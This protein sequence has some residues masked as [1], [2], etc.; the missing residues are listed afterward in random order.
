MKKGNL[1]FRH[2]HT[3]KTNFQFQPFPFNFFFKESTFLERAPG[4]SH[5]SGGP[6]LAGRASFLR[7]KEICELL[8]A[9]ATTRA[10]EGPGAPRDSGRRLRQTRDREK[11]PYSSTTCGTACLRIL[12]RGGSK[13]E[14]ELGLSLRDIVGPGAS[15]S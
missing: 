6:Q 11:I 2:L 7:K 14:P 3:I 8:Y 4:G 10:R 13:A 12:R 1:F 15:A 5:P 9:N